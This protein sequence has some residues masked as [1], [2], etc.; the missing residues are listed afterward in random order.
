MYAL[1][2]KGLLVAFINL[3]LL[4]KGSGAMYKISHLTDI[5]NITNL[6][7]IPDEVKAIACE[8][9]TV[10]DR[11]YG[12]NRDPLNDDGGYAVVLEPQDDI[13]ILA[14][15]GLDIEN[16]YPEYTD[17]IQTSAGVDYCHALILCN[18][19]FGVHILCEKSKASLSLLD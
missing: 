2:N 7:S 10:L 19:E 13:S 1:S 17:A 3:N 9:V 8:I 6:T 14:D 16:L 11:E 12:T 5:P 4:Y 18:N 15:L